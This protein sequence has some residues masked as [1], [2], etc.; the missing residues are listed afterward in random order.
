MSKSN[1]SKSVGS[2]LL[3]EI[4]RPDIYRSNGF[5]ILG[6]PVCAST[7]EIVAQSKKL[8][9]IEKLGNIP[10]DNSDILPISPSPDI[11]ARRLSLQ[12]L[13]NPEFRLIDEIF[14][15]WTL[16]HSSPQDS[17]AALL[18]L[19]K[20][21]L[22]GAVNI[23][24]EREAHVSESNASK[25]N[26]AI[27]YHLLALDLEAEQA[28]RALTS[29]EST[30]KQDYWKES[31]TRWL[32][33]INYEGFWDRLNSRIH[34]LGDP[35]LTEQTLDEIRQGFPIALISINAQLAARAAQ[36]NDKTL[37][38]FHINLMRNS[39]FPSKSIDDVLVKVAAPTNDQ[40]K[41]LCESTD[42][43]VNNAPEAGKQQANLIADKS[44]NLLSSL[45]VLLPLGST[46]LESAHDKVALCIMRA[47]IAYGNKT[48]DWESSLELLS[49][50]I[51]VA[52]SP[53][54]KQ[55]ISDNADIVKSN[56]QY[57]KDF[58]T[59]W[60]CGTNRA[61]SSAQMGVKMHGY[62]ERLGNQVSWRKLEVPVPR[63]VRCKSAHARDSVI[64][65]IG[66]ILGSILGTVGCFSIKAYTWGLFGLLPIAVGAGIGYG[67]GKG[68]G[69]IASSGSKPESHSH[70]FLT[71]R[72]A[73]SEG[74]L[75]GDKPSGVN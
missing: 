72:N 48:E 64:G 32:T 71:V 10:T 41:I 63:C 34:A 25:H 74:W 13:S 12:R 31:F 54:T 3:L 36:K 6:L 59:C 38:L 42:A 16:D 61:D 9:I 51:R 75:F 60:F 35:R 17:D 29:T 57:F 37:S 40:I 46:M 70:E 4:A 66:A 5:R 69:R 50:A 1:S 52:I 2:Q 67:I 24:H 53:S 56:L 47:Q 20:H 21:D 11:Q 8:D 49:K 15:F 18:Y 33:L 19:M 27:L 55:R 23:W 7:R 28:N 68:I 73:F 65:T 22:K 14:W 43:I 62:V 26:L 58:Q 30:L 45:D 39:G 44:A